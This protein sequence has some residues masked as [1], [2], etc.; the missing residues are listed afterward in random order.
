MNA[1]NNIENRIGAGKNLGILR[2]SK[3]TRDISITKLE[4]IVDIAPTIT[5]APAYLN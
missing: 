2:I 3:H 5:A 4:T 1:A